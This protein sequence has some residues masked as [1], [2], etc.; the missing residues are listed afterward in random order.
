[1][2]RV[3]RRGGWN[4]GPNPGRLAQDAV[5]ILPELLAKKLA[6]L[7][8]GEEDRQ[9]AAPIR[10]RLSLRMSELS[11]GTPSAPSSA[12][13]QAKTPP[14]STLDERME[15][16][17]RVA[18]GLPQSPPQS[19]PAPARQHAAIENLAAFS[20][21]QSPESGALSRLLLAWYEQGVLE[22]RL[23]AL[24]QEQLETWHRQLR[25]DPARVSVAEPDAALAQSIETLIVSHSA[26]LPSPSLPENL[27]CR[28][29]IVVSI[30]LKLHLPL[31]SR[32]SWQVLDRLLPLAPAL[33]PQ[34]VAA[35]TANEAHGMRD[36]PAAEPSH[37][38][39]TRPSGPPESAPAALILHRPSSDWEVK[40][41]CALP[42]LLLGPL[43]RLG[44][45]DTLAAVLEAAHLSPY[46]PL[47][48]A[49]LAYKV[50]DPPQRGWRRTPASLEAAAAMSALTS[51]VAEESLVEFARRMAPHTAAL[52]LALADALIAGHTKREPVTIRGDGGNGFLLLDTQGCFPIAFPRQSEMLVALLKQLGSPIVL[53]SHEA[54]DIRLLDELNTAGVVFLIDVP[55]AR[56]EPWRRLQQVLPGWTNYAGPPAEP[57]HRAAGAMQRAWEEA[58]VLA[59]E[60]GPARPSVIRAASP[61]LDRS[62]TLA[63]AVALGMIA[64][65][66]WQ[67]RGP[68]SPQQMLERY[69]DLEARVRFDSSSVKVSLPLGR[70]HRELHE[71]GFL[72]PISGVP[73]L[74]TR[75]IEFGGG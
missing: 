71:N 16:A 69:G 4:W 50:L 41:A 37:V 61:E 47:F 68:T 42:L 26:Y 30:A 9:I 18:L 70:R 51:P 27:C 35:S 33:P 56:G 34:P 52:D 66:L 59:E 55:P 14:F 40:I 39:Q 5:R 54:A 46:G 13:P 60:L 36:T 74:G 22:R 67:G 72:A 11:G 48:A 43:A 6:E 15:S 32:E 65:K 62:L 45:L 24:P 17:L 19:P 28:L 57:L 20:H 23:A 29:L 10:I 75:R 44:Y 73:W 64:W 3:I 2:L 53:V 21:H 58:R 31:N 8:S 1:M 63:A 7:L 49:A 38:G 25:F 12:A